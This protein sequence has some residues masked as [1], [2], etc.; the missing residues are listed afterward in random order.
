MG[1]YSAH[2]ISHEP[3]LPPRDGGTAKQIRAALEHV[4]T[5]NSGQN[6]DSVRVALLEAWTGVGNG[7]SISEPDLT[8]VA[9]LISAGKRVWLEADGRII[10]ED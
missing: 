1:A 5:S 8:T 9:S 3:R 10:A 7:A 4:S 6:I 2:D